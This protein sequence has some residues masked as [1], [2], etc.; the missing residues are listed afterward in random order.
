MTAVTRSWP[1]RLDAA[2]LTMQALRLLNSVI[3]HP[4]NHGRAGQAILRFLRWQVVSR[5]TSGAIETPFVDDTV[6]LIGRSASGAS[7]NVYYGLAEWVDMAFCC[8]L[9]R[10]GDLFVDVGATLGPTR[11]SPPGRQKPRRSASSPS[12]PWMHS[13]Q[14]GIFV[15]DRS[16][17]A[18]RLAA[19]RRFKTQARAI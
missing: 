14:N 7:G 13:D 12:R 19:A 2:D 11:F 15:R 17:V 16:A 3:L 5:L 9:L 1:L 10:E 18:E 8:H 6:L 4:M